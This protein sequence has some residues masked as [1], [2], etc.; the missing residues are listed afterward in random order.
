MFSR[1]ERG[2]YIDLLVAQ[3]NHGHLSIDEI[4]HILGAEFHLWEKIK[5]KFKSDAD[6]KFYNSRLDDEKI[7]RKSYSES[8]RKNVSKRY[9]T[10]LDSTCVDTHESTYVEHMNLHM[11]NENTNS[12]VVAVKGGVGG[13]RYPHLV[14]KCPHFSD[15]EFH[16]LWAA[17]VEVK[18]KKNSPL[19]GKSQSLIF[20]KLSAHPIATAKKMLEASIA[21]GYTDVYEPKE[22]KNGKQSSLADALK[23]WDR[24]TDPK[25]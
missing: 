8:R 12:S 20:S 4:Q 22:S 23:E 19:T 16:E 13:K 21:A 14:D 1:L 9:E 17:F 11:E 7:K 10:S 18:V 25:S 3:F 6:G 24:L 2:A 5:S 15:P